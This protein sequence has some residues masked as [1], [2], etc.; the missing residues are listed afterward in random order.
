MTIQDYYL[1]LLAA[2]GESPLDE[3]AV[4]EILQEIISETV[5]TTN[6]LESLSK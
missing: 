6:K 4:K 2:W 1:E 3:Q 5:K